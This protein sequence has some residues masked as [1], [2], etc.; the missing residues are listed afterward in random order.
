MVFK[1]ENVNLQLNQLN[2][3]KKKFK[4]KIRFP[5]WVEHKGLPLRE[6]FEILWKRIVFIGHTLNLASDRH[7]KLS[8]WNLLAGFSKAVCSS[9][10]PWASNS[11]H[12]VS[13][14]VNKILN[15]PFLTFSI[16]SQGL[17]CEER[18]SQMMNLLHFESTL[19]QLWVI[20][21]E[22]TGLTQIITTLVPGQRLWPLNGFKGCSLK[23]WPLIR[24]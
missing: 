24:I 5:N 18:H 1:F 15:F 16:A 3:F 12:Q 9:G 19:N 22:S 11:T 20:Q 7:V 8:L 13:I 2:W 4:L 17:I 14:E 23:G 10:L 6:S 21:I